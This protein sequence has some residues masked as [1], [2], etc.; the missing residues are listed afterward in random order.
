MTKDVYTTT[1]AARLC[2]LS[3]S[4]I[5]RCFDSGEL[6]GFRVPG[7]RFRRIPRASLLGFMKKNGIPIPNDVIAG[8]VANEA[9]RMLIVEDDADTQRVIEKTFAHDNRFDI[10][11][12]VDGFTAGFQVVSFKPDIVLLDILLPGVDGR[13]VCRLIRRVP[14]LD[15]VKI[16]AVTGVTGPEKVKALFA[17]GIDDY[18]AKPFTA[19]ILRAKVEALLQG[20]D[21]RVA[22]NM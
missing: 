11:T 1:E 9:L 5:I 2:R 19:D 10:R 16:L 15:H 8:S 7:S 14:G 20:H 3:N 18:L 21:L 4:T 13:E 12:A 17:A 22:D 6:L